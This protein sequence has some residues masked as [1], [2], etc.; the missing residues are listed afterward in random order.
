[1]LQRSLFFGVAMSVL[2]LELA[3]QS[4]FVPDYTEADRVLD[5]LQT[6]GGSFSGNLHLASKPLNQKAVTAYLFKAKSNIY[7]ASI[8][9]TDMYNINKILYGQAEWLNKYGGNT[10]YQRYNNP[11]GPIYKNP[12]QLFEYNKPNRFYISI[13]PKLGFQYLNDQ[14]GDSIANRN[15][16]VAGLELKSTVS[17]R[18]SVYASYTYNSEDPSFIF[19]NYQATHSALPGIEQYGDVTANNNYNYHLFRGHADIKVL[20]DY[21]NLTLGYGAPRIGD[22]YRSLMLSDFAGASWFARLQTTIWKL[23]YQNIYSVYQ[24]QTIFRGY[25][26]ATREAKYATTHHL[27]LDVF[28]WLNVGLFES[29]VFGRDDRYEFGYLNPIIFYR[30]VERA[31][32]SPDKIILGVNAKAIPVR[33]F[34]VYGQFIINEFSASEFF[35]NNGYWANKWGGQLGFNY[36]DVF[37]IS[38]LDMQVEAN[39]VR[40]F[41]YTSS[42]KITNQIL[43]NY[44]HY[45]QSLAHPLGAAFQEVV[46]NLRYQ[47]VRKL[48][49]DA[50]GVFYQQTLDNN[51]PVTNGVNILRDYSSRTKDYGFKIVDADSNR[52]VVLANLNIAYELWYNAYLEL[53]MNYRRE[54]T[55][56]STG[57]SDNLGIY[58]GF[59]INLQRRDYAQF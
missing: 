52:N 2:S 35:S 49:I 46:L 25:T 24:P 34:N 23:K 42:R 40:P 26:G 8:S 44:T 12:T 57:S 16:F 10:I 31:M 18:V 21:I 43:T 53:G 48:K 32:G 51:M 58:A 13:N 27:S 19:R 4:A 6:M 33:N 47:P 15:Y 17:D 54:T 55:T 50:R 9:N 29:V 36:Y 37:N 22:G 56:I 7:N 45:N 3:A 14:Q 38:N 30:S 20:K 5:R 39:A 11:L 41:T 28:K 1:M 59:R